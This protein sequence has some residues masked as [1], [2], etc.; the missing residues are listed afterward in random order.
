M[1]NISGLYPSNPH[2]T[3]IPI[4]IFFIYIGAVFSGEK[5]KD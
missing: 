1:K 4:S 5:S 2:K 3:V